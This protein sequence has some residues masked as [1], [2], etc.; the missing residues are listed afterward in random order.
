[1][2]A[3]AILSEIHRIREKQA[4]ECAFDPK[5]IGSRMHARQKENAARRVRYA[6]FAEPE[7]R[8]VREYPPKR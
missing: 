8:I 3:E 4:A 2:K 5:Q 7:S 1:M 6:N